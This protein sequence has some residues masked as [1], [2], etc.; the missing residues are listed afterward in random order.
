MAHLVY[1]C[2]STSHDRNTL[3]ALEPTDQI[4]SIGHISWHITRVVPHPFCTKETSSKVSQITTDSAQAE[5][6]GY[7]S[8]IVIHANSCCAR[9]I[10]KQVLVLF[11]FAAWANFK[12]IV[13]TTLGHQIW[14]LSGLLGCSSIACRL[15]LIIWRGS[16]HNFLHDRLDRIIVVIWSL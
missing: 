12:F 8:A 14:L 5:I 2:F 11:L 15:F 4:W 7:M 3:R 9:I 13:A 1:R 10:A 6:S 16:S